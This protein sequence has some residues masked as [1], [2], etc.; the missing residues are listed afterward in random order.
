MKA[1]LYLSFLFICVS[2][3]GQQSDIKDS[4]SFQTE[5]E[6]VVFSVSHF[7]ETKKNIAQQIR[8]I[9]NKQIGRINAQNSGDLLMNSGSAFVQ[10]S[11][12]GGSS[13]VIRGFEA[14]RV[15]LVVDGIRM[16]NAIYRS[17]HLQNIITV[18]QQMVDRVEILYGPASTLYGSDALG[19]VVHFRTLTP[20]TSDSG[21]RVSGNLMARYSSANQE[22]TVHADISIGLKKWAALSSFTYSDF[23]DLK[24]GSHDPDGYRGFGRR[25]FYVA[26]INGMDSIM[27]NKDDRIQRFSG[28]LQW[29]LL[30]KMVFRP[31]SRTSHQLNL[32][33]SGSSDVPRYDRLQD[34]SGS[35][36]RFAQWYYGPQ[37]RTLLA[38]QFYQ[39]G[40]KEMV[41]EIR[42]N[43]HY[44]RIGESRHQRSYRS[45]NLDNRMEKV[46]VTGFN[47]DG[48]KN[49][50]QHEIT[51]GL[52]GQVNAVKSTAFRTDIQS[53]MQTKI[54]SRYPDGSNRMYYAGIFGQHVYKIIPG[55]LILN[56]GLRL[57]WVSLRSTIIDTA[58]QLHLPFTAIEQQNLA[59][60]GNIGI[61]FLPSAKTKWSA[62]IASGFRNPNID[63][64]SKIFESNPSSRQL[65][66]PNPDLGPE[67]TYTADLVFEREFASAFRLSA[68][69]F[70]TWFRNAIVV[71]PFR[72]NG[73]DSVLYNGVLSA[74]LASQNRN[75]ARVYGAGFAVSGRFGQRFSYSG[76]M[77]FSRGSFKTDA[78]QPTAIYRKQSDGSYKKVLERVSQKPLDHIPPVYG[79]LG[80]L[81]EHKR[82]YAEFF[83]LFNGWKRLEDYNADG[84][85]NA[86]YATA[87]GMPGWYTL[88]FRGE[89]GVTKMIRVQGGIENL[90]DRNYRVFASGF[91]APGRNFWL[92]LR[93]SF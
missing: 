72:L 52:D 87:D 15:L 16:N 67:Y 25:P 47:L 45:Q 61:A 71:A 22:Q 23:D 90:L 49:L 54:D 86:Q 39:S 80:L 73:L 81:Y 38:Y 60:T 40:I 42:F 35:L 31:S 77:Q 46:D 56:D 14:S 21:T 13:P 48:R 83:T 2:A 5:L 74:V 19:G 63:D 68:N 26:R 76:N 62:G 55:R 10:K 34:Q 8:I 70:Y 75:R 7:R 12:Q 1:V 36:P 88:N 78:D 6:E 30:Q 4:S 84:E 32:Q 64:L 85:D 69:A 24:M 82:F 27:R 41:D 44:Q 17:G 3:I 29:D 33:H 92:A 11:Q 53:G 58:V 28:Y 9:S 93:A 91:S 65:I 20:S 51:V 57:Q 43:L 50:R 59:L 18:D 89:F 37:N 79:R 66:V